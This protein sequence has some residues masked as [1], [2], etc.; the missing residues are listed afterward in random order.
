MK[1]IFVCVFLSVMANSVWSQWS[2]KVLSK[3]F[4]QYKSLFVQ[5]KMAS[6]ESIIMGD[7]F[8]LMD[9]IVNNSSER[10]IVKKRDKKM[11]YKKIHSLLDSTKMAKIYFGDVSIVPHQGNNSFW[12]VSFHQAIVTA[13]DSLSGTMFIL[14]E[15]QDSPDDPRTSNYWEHEYFWQP[16]FIDGI[17]YPAESKIT[18]ND[19]FIP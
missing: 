16:D 14:Y 10:E 19:I 18:L 1:R 15:L 6:L 5:K 12:G 17:P 9:S 3:A 2:Q 11:F 13:K 4:E 8:Y 7:N